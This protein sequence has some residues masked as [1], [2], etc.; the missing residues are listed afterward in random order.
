MMEDDMFIVI[1]S[2]HSKHYFPN[3]SPSH[4]R[5]CLDQFIDFKDAHQCA[6]MD[7]T[8]TTANFES[9]LL[10][11]YIYFNLVSEQP[12]GGSRESL[13]RHTTVR[14]GQLQ[15]EKFTLPYYLPVK[16]IRTNTLEVYIRDKDGKQ[17]SFLKKTTT[18]TFHFRKKAW[19][20]D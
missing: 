19:L 13:V 6:L 17:A 9:P 18:C 4:F 15:M 12:V 5:V 1:S 7:F 3:N 11:I 10:N 8:C 14:R 20:T 16:P 2:Q